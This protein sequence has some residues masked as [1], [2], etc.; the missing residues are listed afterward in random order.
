MG[1]LCVSVHQR[2]CTGF[3]DCIYASVFTFIASLCFYVLFSF[4]HMYALRA[5]WYEGCMLH[6][7]ADSA[8]YTQHACDQLYYQV[9]CQ[10]I[11][12]LY[13]PQLV[14]C[15]LHWTNEHKEK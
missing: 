9:Q 3:V 6:M 1:G 4:F 14:T 15:L 8:V 10:T 5:F 11:V 2:M 12:L 7:W 13:R